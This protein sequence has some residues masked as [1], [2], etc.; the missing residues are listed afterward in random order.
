M[1][2]MSGAFLS[3]LLTGDVQMLASGFPTKLQ[4]YVNPTFERDV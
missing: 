2:K 3:S 1:G 4:I